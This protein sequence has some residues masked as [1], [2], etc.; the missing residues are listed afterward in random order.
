MQIKTI[1]AIISILGIGCARQEVTQTTITRDYKCVMKDLDYSKYQSQIDP[2]F[3]YAQDVHELYETGRG[4]LEKEEARRFP[5]DS[6]L[7]G[8]RRSNNCSFG[9]SF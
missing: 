8:S 9:Y 6:S 4:V 7:Y 3:N 5:V 2:T 1:I